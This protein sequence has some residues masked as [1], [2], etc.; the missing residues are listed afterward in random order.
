MHA[1]N[2]DQRPL[3]ARHGGKYGGHGVNKGVNE[4]PAVTSLTDRWE[5]SQP[6]VFKQGKDARM[7]ARL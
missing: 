2:T 3:H 6:D 1:T 5:F 4:A 7:R